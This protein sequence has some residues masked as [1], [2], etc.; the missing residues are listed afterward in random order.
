[1]GLGAALWFN[2][3]APGP[4]VVLVGFGITS[5]SMQASMMGRHASASSPDDGGQ[6]VFAGDAGLIPPGSRVPVQ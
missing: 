1:M 3:Y 5:L 4:W 2:A 6:V